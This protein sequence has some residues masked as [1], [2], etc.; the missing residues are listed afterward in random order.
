MG[1]SVGLS[2]AFLSIY[3]VQMQMYTEW[4]WS[5]KLNLGL[6]IPVYVYSAVNYS[7]Y[8]Y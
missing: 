6:L 2:F 3:S 1:N 4:M 8:A 7:K 5:S